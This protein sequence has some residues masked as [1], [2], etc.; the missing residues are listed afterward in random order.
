L[1]K[2]CESIEKDVKEKGRLLEVVSYLFE[3]DLSR[4]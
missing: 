2:E 1:T 4:K 3:K